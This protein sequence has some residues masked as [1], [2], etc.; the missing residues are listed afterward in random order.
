MPTR[1]ERNWK[2][3]WWDVESHENMKP[4]DNGCDDLVLMT[5]NSSIIAVA[6]F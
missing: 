2:R 4:N 1:L 5:G 6:R 3:T